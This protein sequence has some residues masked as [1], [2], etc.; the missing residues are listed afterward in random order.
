M[1]L[2]DA[3]KKTAKKSKKV[4]AVRTKPTVAQKDRPYQTSSSDSARKTRQRPAVIAGDLVVSL[5]QQLYGAAKSRI[6]ET[7][8]TKVKARAEQ[9]RG[10]VKKFARA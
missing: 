5:A 10:F 6:T 3:L 4:K 2:G 7:Y 1:Q 9:L 8:E